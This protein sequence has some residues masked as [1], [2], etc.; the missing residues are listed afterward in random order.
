LLENSIAT[1]GKWHYITAFIVDYL[2]M[3]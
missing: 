1:M 3:Q 2:G